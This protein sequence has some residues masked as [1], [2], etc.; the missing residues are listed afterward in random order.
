MKNNKSWYLTA[1]IKEPD[2]KLFKILISF[3]RSKTQIQLALF[4]ILLKL[5]FQ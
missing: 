3:L 1:A 4:F 2:I 5:H